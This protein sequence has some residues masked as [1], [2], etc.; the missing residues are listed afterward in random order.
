MEVFLV[1]RVEVAVAGPKSRNR[2]WDLVARVYPDDPA[3]P[4]GRGAAATRRAGSGEIVLP[5]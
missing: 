4:T 1:S 2:L 5:D 3:C